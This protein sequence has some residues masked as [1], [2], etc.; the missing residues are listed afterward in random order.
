MNFKQCF[1]ST[2]C[3]GWKW[4][5]YHNVKRGRLWVSVGE[6]AVPQ[7]RRGLH[8]RKAL[9]CV[10]WN[11][12]GVIYLEQP[13]PIKPSQQRSTG[14]CSKVWALDYRKNVLHRPIARVLCFIRS[15]RVLIP[16]KSHAPKS[17]SWVG[18]KLRI[19][20]IRRTL[21]PP[22]TTYSEVYKTIST[23]KSLR[24]WRLSK[25]TSPQFPFQSQ[26]NL[27]KMELKSL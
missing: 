25:A 2:H 1:E 22:I 18:K 16:L 9:L 21:H 3:W 24:V 12:L 17:K 4:V 7:A 14:P 11:V 6:P 20:R 13:S 8:L 27:I 10:W 26:R 5:L 15:S 19:R 23:E